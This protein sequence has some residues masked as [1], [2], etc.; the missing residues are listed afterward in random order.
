MTYFPNRS[1]VSTTSAMIRMPWSAPL[2]TVCRIG[3]RLL[4]LSSDGSSPLA[5]A[6]ASAVL[7]TISIA[8]GTWSSIGASWGVPW[9]CLPAALPTATVA[10][11]A[12]RLLASCSAASPLNFSGAPV[13]LSWDPRTPALGFWTPPVSVLTNAMGA[14]GN[15]SFRD[16]GKMTRTISVVNIVGSRM[17]KRHAMK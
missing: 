16:W 11:L 13:T 7:E 17:S 6:C 14:G 15:S 4:S 5:A 10:T 3:S 8:S 1:Q 2:S 9:S 12:I